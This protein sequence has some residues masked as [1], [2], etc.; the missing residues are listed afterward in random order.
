MS[1]ISEA[2]RPASAVPLI[3]ATPL[4]I[5]GPRQVMSLKTRLRAPPRY[6]RL[7]A[8]LQISRGLLLQIRGCS[9]ALQK[10]RR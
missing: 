7:R 3:P 5:S 10:L 8:P 1:T 4:Q 2:L 9:T 6:N